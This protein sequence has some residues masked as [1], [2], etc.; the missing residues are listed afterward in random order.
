MKDLKKVIDE[1]KSL[2]DEDFKPSDDAILIS[3]TTSF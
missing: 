2:K 3:A 1:V